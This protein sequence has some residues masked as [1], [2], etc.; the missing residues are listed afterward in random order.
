MSF[1]SAVANSKVLFGCFDIFQKH[2]MDAKRSD[3][4]EAGGSGVGN[5]Y[6]VVQ[7]GCR[8]LSQAYGRV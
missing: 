1:G 5:T 3:V 2:I 7:G 8:A 4:S 6:G